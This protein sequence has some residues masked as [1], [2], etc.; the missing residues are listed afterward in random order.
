MIIDK[1]KIECVTFLKPKDHA[2]VSTHSHAPKPFQFPFQRMQPPAGKQPNFIGALRL[3]YRQQDVGDLL[4]QS[5]WEIPAVPVS[6]Q[7]PQA[8]IPN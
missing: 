4:H 7:S 1:I 3:V 2:P 8:S 5:C 6:V